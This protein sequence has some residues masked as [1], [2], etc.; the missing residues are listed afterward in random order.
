[1]TNISDITSNERGIVFYAIYEPIIKDNKQIGQ[2]CHRVSII[3][4]A[5]ITNQPQEVIDFCNNI[6]TAEVISNYRNS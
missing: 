2:S 6:W 4:S 5:D 1:M 3:P